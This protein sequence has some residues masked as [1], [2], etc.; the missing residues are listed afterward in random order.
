MIGKEQSA[1][2]AR[3]LRLHNTILVFGKG[4]RPVHRVLGEHAP[5][6]VEAYHILQEEVY[7]GVSEIPGRCGST[8]R[9]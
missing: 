5:Q 9:A 4:D 2:I 7:Y 1:L 3:V 6:D 8:C